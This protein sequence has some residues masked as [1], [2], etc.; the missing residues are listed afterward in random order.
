MSTERRADRSG[1]RMAPA[2]ASTGIRHAEELEH[3]ASVRA[4][5]RTTTTTVSSSD[6][7]LERLSII[8]GG[9]GGGSR[10]RG[11]L[12]GHIVA[13]FCTVQYV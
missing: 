1:M 10:A 12:S 3:H 8:E 11:V 7:A 2:A 5:S 9:G 13:E 4:V 6:H